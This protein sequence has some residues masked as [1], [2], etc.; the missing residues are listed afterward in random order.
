MISEKMLMEFDHEA[1]NTRKVLERV[2][3]EKLGW[4][5]HEKSMTMGILTAHLAVLSEMATIVLTTESYDVLVP[6]DLLKKA[7]QMTHTAELLALF[8]ES[9]ARARAALATADDATMMQ[10]WT[11]NAGE[12]TIFTLP[13]VA[14][15]RIMYSNHA[16]HHRAQLGVYLRMND[17][18]LPALYGPSADE[19]G[20]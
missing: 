6:N 1:A 5:P 20:M 17:I 10:M 9:I 18:P 14:V 15:L 16:I 13:R 12:N 8:D 2:P 11:L 3:E 7:K 19:Y 4:K